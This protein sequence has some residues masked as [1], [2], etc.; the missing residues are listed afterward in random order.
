VPSDPEEIAA[1][2]W[3]DMRV[4]AARLAGDLPAPETTVSRPT[5]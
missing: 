1:L 3:V 5:S 2:S 4:L